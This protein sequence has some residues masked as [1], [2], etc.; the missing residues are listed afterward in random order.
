MAAEL[1]QAQSL[2]EA[3]AKLAEQNGRHAIDEASKFSGKIDLMITDVVMPGMSGGQLA[4]LLAAA[5]PNMKV[6]FVSGYAEKV[7][8]NHQI[9]DLSNNF[10]Q[11]PFTLATLGS[12]MREVLGRTAAAVVPGRTGHTRWLIARFHAPYNRACG[13]LHEPVGSAAGQENR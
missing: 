12:K 13:L 5:R 6:L 4:E 8:M 2:E 9:L 1:D 10:L 11:K 7:V 3:Q